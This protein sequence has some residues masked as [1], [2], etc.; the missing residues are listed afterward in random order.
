MNRRKCTALLRKTLLGNTFELNESLICAGGEQG[1]DSCKGDGGSPL[2]CPV[3]GNKGHFYQAGIVAWG[4]GC[5]T[6]N[7]PGAYTNVAFFSDWIESR[8]RNKSYNSDSY[9]L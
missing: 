7:I 5:G 3:P 8:L 1:V 4:I 9:K 2:V 6:S